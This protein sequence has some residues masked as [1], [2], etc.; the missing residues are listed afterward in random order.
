MENEDVTESVQLDLIASYD[1]HFKFG[2][3][4][5]AFLFEILSQICPKKINKEAKL[6]IFLERSIFC[7]S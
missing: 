6:I 7:L 2:F 3:A 5:Y 4:T 1:L